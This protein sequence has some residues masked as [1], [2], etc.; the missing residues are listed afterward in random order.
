[1]VDLDR[2]IE[3]TAPKA[4]SL[5][6]TPEI[7]QALDDIGID[8]D[9][10]GRIKQIWL[11]TR[12]D[13]DGTHHAAGYSLFLAPSWETGPEWPVVQPAKPVVVRVPKA[14]ATKV[15]DGW[16]TAVVHPD[17]Q[18]GF[19]RLNDGTLD[20]FHD[21]RALSIA[22]Q[23]TERVRPDVSILLGDT[24]DLAEFGRFRLDPGMAGMTQATIDRAH[25]YI[26]TVAEMS[27]RTLLFQ[28]NHDLRLQNYILDNA[29]A[30]FGIK[31]ANVPDD[32]PAMSVRSLLRL[33][34]LGVEYMDG[35]P[36][37]RHYLTPR[38]RISHG[39][40][41]KSGGSTAAMLVKDSA[42][43]DIFGHVHV[44]QYHERTIEEA[45]ADGRPTHR[46]IFGYSPGC[47]CRIDGA[48]PGTNSGIDEHGRPVVSWQNW[49]QGV[50]VLHYH[51]TE[52][53]WVEHVAISD[54]VAWF[55]GER[56]E[57]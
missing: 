53:P 55:R 54:G 6:A 44:T 27:G 18:F 22:V 48:T 14:K 43:S 52:D 29:A 42:E 30:A 38:L 16:Q 40:R 9:E 50:G 36:A 41:V 49:Q 20:P 28:G 51:A 8:A 56:F 26:S 4:N 47:L 12:T 33:D 46:R 23:I 37:N 19:R 35:Y 45:G 13:E 5:G 2:I 24:L 25:G 1:M 15:V 57:A 21:E 31:R 39:S 10:V 32:W 11:K 17:P 7:R 34:E 3:D